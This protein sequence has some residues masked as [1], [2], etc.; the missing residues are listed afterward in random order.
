MQYA[1]AHARTHAHT[2]T[3]AQESTHALINVWLVNPRLIATLPSPHLHDGG[4]RCHGDDLCV[5]IVNELLVAAFRSV[6]H[7]LAGSIQIFDFIPQGSGA[8][9]L[10]LRKRLS[11]AGK[12]AGTS[13]W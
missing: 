13:S 5:L 7:R 9:W 6:F 1:G 11:S 10:H 4:C 8:D 12:S 2:H 3:Y